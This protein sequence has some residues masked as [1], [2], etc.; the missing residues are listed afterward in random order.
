M[1]CGVRLPRA[2]RSSMSNFHARPDSII[3]G[4][5]V[6]ECERV[7]HTRTH[8]LRAIVSVFPAIIA[9]LR[10]PARGR[11]NRSRNAKAR[12]CVSLCPATLHVITAYGMYGIRVATRSPCTRTRPRCGADAQSVWNDNK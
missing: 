9:K 1:Q 8:A 6:R 3:S 5:F 4:A 11:V 2:L 12:K 7:T 10:S